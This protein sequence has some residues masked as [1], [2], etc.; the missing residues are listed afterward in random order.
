LRAEP[1]RQARSIALVPDGTKVEAIGLAEM[2]GGLSWRPVRTG[3][4]AEG[5]MAV[6]FL[7]TDN[8]TD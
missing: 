1:S 7:S 6:D 8:P 3:S 4:G 5:W 2:H